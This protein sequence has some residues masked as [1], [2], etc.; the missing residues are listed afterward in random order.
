MRLPIGKLSKHL[1]FRYIYPNIGVTDSSVIIGP[2]WG[3]DAAVIKYDDK[4]L[5]F[6]TD[7]ITAAKK[8]IGILSVNIATNDVAVMGAKPRWLLTTFLLSRDITTEDL[9]NI[10]LQIDQAAKKLGISIIG[11]HTEVTPSIDHTIIVST[12]VGETDKYIT[13]QNVKVDDRVILVKGIAIEGTGILAHELEDKLLSMG[14]SN[15]IIAEAKKYIEL[16]SIVKEAL[17]IY[18]K[19]KDNISSMHDPTEGGLFAALHEIADAA[20]V[21]I[22]LHINKVFL[23]KETRE[24]CEVLNI[25]PYMLISSGSLII[26]A[27]ESIADNIVEEFKRIGVWANVIG[28]IRNRRFGRKINVDGRYVKLPRPAKDEIWK[29]IS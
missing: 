17:F 10:M 7:P 15:K 25:N 8:Y 4:Y 3:V 21:G 26:T 9:D 14:I 19:Y 29:V 27:D 1:M 20:N 23:S 12:A 6:S 13:T 11:G 2:T 22:E 5:V 16:T 28:I 18:E 24:I